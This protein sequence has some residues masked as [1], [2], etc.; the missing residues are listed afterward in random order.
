MSLYL[1]YNFFWCLAGFVAG[2]TS[3]GG[4][5]VAVPF[6]T[7]VMDPRDAILS[8][9]VSGTAVFI[10]ISLVYW[11]HALWGE[12]LRL[13]LGAAA[14]IPLGVWFLGKSG[15][16][17]IL[18]TAGGCIILFLCWQF[19][20]ERLHR[21]EKAISS[22]YA[23]PFGLVSGILMGAVGMGGPPL[24]LYS[25]LRRY[26]KE[27]TLGTV[28]VASVAFMAL[29]LPWQY[30]SGFYSQHVLNL[31]LMGAVFAF[32]GIAASIPVVRRVNIRIFRLLLLGMLAISAITLI[33]RAI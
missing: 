15:A 19:F 24:V 18:L 2:V 26:S 21:A 10:G 23:L 3:F 30:F 14:G 5:L 12:A 33:A 9:C 4:N 1:Y 6:I 17:A 27:E 22:I 25:F 8:G 11:R 29:V 28:N 13:T 7:L 16:S 32:C 20:S 31:G